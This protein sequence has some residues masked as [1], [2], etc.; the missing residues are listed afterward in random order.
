MGANLE[1][2]RGTLTNLYQES[3]ATYEGFVQFGT[4][5]TSQAD[6]G[7]FPI[8]RPSDGSTAYSMEAWFY[9]KVENAPENN[10]TNIRF[11]GSG[12]NP[13]T[14]AFM[15]V[16]TSVSS[17]TPLMTKSTYASVNTTTYTDYDNSLLWSD[18]TLTDV[19]DKSFLL[20]M[21]VRIDS[22]VSIGTFSNEATVYHYSYDES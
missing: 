3:D 15:Y 17:S 1:L 19:N 8:G 20:V 14:G 10:I 4:Q 22:S 7:L 5:D 16:G 18:K 11:W 6:G 12:S 9:L 21:Q 2:K 13:G